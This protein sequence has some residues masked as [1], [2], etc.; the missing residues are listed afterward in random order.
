M[1]RKA[2]GKLSMGTAVTTEPD[3]PGL[4]SPSRLAESC[5]RRPGLK[6]L[7]RWPA[8]ALAAG[9]IPIFVLLAGCGGSASGTS[10]TL[11][12]TP[13][14]TTIDT[15]CTGCNATNHSGGSVEQFSATLSGS[16][17]TVNW[18]VSGGD[19]NAGAGS[20]SSTGQYTPPPYLTADSVKV[21]V[22]ATVASGTGAGTSGSASITVTPGFLEPLSPENVA[23]GSNGTVTIA[24]YIAEAGG[25]TGINYAVSNS[26]TGSGGGEGSLGQTSCARSSNEFTHCTVTYT[27]P[28]TVSATAATYIVGTVGTSSSKTASLVLLNSAGISSNPATHQTQLSTPILLGSSGGNNSDYDTAVQNGQTNIVDCCG[29][30]LGSMIQSSGGTQYLLSAIMCWRAAIRPQWA[31]RLFSRGSLTTTARPTEMAREL[32]RWGY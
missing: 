7:R 12:V 19:A 4:L 21:T 15:N 1:A 13:G 16:A 11:A 31:K 29:G 18:T 22:T 5:L 9:T 23:L 20:I 27:A 24:G 25:S 10:S 3:K 14:S 28:A 8:R 26:A 6:L 17:A 2:P 30:T 32:R